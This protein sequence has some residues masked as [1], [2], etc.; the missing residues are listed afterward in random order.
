MDDIGNA[1]PAGLR[2]PLKAGGDVDAISENVLVIEDDVAEIDPET[3]GN[4]ALYWGGGF[5]AP[6]PLD[7]ECATDRLLRRGELAE[8]AVACGLDDAPAPLAI[9]GSISSRR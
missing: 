5:A 3:V 7:V 2:Q 8:H 4:P 9:S 6:S 1:H